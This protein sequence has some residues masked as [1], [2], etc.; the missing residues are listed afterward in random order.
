[1]KQIS[2]IFILLFMAISSSLTAANKPAAK[3]SFKILTFNLWVGGDG[4]GFEKS[5]SV[6]A[7]LRT[8]RE[9]NSDIVAFQEQTSHK[10]GISSRAQELADSLSWNCIII[11][12]SRAVISKHP[13][14]RL[15]GDESQ[16]LKF[17][18]DGKEFIVADVH[19]PAYPYQPYDIADGKILN[20]ADAVMAAKAARGKQIASVL[21]ERK[22]H[23][24]LPMIVLGDF[25]E[26]SYYDWS[27][28][29]IQQRKD[30]R[31]TFPVQWPSTYLLVEAGFQ[32]SYRINHKNVQKKP[33]YTWTS[34]PGGSIP[35]E[36]HD[37]IDLIFT[38]KHFKSKKQWIVGEHK[39]MADI[40][41]NPWPTDHRAVLAEL[42]F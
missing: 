4:S 39:E 23:E 15:N 31:L 33:A 28:K 18:L 38:T 35:N 5:K 14:Q 42:H 22:G 24:Q 36:V 7:Q 9:T 3:T 34:I 29:A 26:P 25:N 27:A 6:A 21:A 37:R 10:F 11:D 17:N 13:M 8:I 1:M 12:R 41:I 2:S 30:G 40:V 19:L 20:A 32:D 16:L